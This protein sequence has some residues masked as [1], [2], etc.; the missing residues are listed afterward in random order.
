MSGTFP[1]S[2]GF[3][4]IR[5]RLK[6]YNLS[7][8]SVNGRIQVRSLGSTRREFTLKFPPMTKAEF[9]PIHEF[10]DSQEGTL[11]TFSITLPDPDSP[12]YAFTITARLANDV[13]EFSLG[14]DNLY[15]FEVDIIEVV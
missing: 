7:S 8:E 4:E 6:H 1:A 13:Q 14:V 11:G 15:E 9:E 2:P 3:T 5:T 10:I 12:A